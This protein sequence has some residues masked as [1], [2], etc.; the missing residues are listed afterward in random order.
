MNGQYAL[1]L[2]KYPYIRID[3]QDDVESFSS[4]GLFGV[5][6]HLGGT[7]PSAGSSPARLTLIPTGDVAEA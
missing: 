3:A 5:Q 7:H 2:Y 4:L 6:C 1:R